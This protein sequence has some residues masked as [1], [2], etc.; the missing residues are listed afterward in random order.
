METQTVG[1]ATSN[2]YVDIVG[3]VFFFSNGQ[4]NESYAQFMHNEIELA[5]V[6]QTNHLLQIIHRVS[7]LY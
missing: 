2:P 6:P 4:M 7:V 1:L 3:F 5:L